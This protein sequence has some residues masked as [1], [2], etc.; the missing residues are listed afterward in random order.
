ML[1]P[2]GSLDSDTNFLEAFGEDVGAV[3]GGVHPIL[4]DIFDGLLTT[5]EIFSEGCGEAAAVAVLR[6]NIAVAAALDAILGC[7]PFGRF[8]AEEI[9]V[10]HI[11]CIRLRRSL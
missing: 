8:V 4:H 5:G 1:D 10:L 11:L 7:F 3:R 9:S 2:V 6:G